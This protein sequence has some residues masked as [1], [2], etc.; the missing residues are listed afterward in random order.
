MNTQ[1]PQLKKIVEK[2]NERNKYLEIPFAERIVEEAKRK[3][4]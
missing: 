4:K 3:K 2:C 1:I